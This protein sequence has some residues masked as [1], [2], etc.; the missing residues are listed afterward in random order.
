MTD[1]PTEFAAEAETGPRING[2]IDVPRPGRVAGWAIDRADPA[3]AVTVT[4]I[5]EGRVVGEVVANA[6]RPDLERGGIGT[7][8]YGFALDLDPPLEP[9]FE[10]TV[11][12]FARATD[13]TSGEIRPVGKAKPTENPSRRLAERA[14]AELVALR[15]A[16]GSLAARRE[17]DVEARVLEALDR[18]EIVQARIEQTHSPVEQPARERHGRGLF[19][20]V[21]LALATGAA[22]LALGIWSMLG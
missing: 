15:A 16:V 5:R 21:G 3:A 10:F 13:G 2:V 12:A 14:F 7:G 19:V 1:M 22:S 6:H 17:V 9:G 18:V 8:R 4:V 20:A 11:S